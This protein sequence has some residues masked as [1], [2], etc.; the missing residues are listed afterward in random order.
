MNNPVSLGLQ[1]FTPSWMS[2]PPT[3]HPELLTV[4]AAEEKSRV[5]ASAKEDDPLSDKPSFSKCVLPDDVMMTI[6]Y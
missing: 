2:C 1:A 5:K 3:F 4:Y 6:I